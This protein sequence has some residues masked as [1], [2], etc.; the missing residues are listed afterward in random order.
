MKGL[1]WIRAISKGSWGIGML[2]VLFL[3]GCNGSSNQQASQSST[4][5]NGADEPQTV[6][7]T[8]PVALPDDML[9]ASPDSARSALA[10]PT[11]AEAR[12]SQVSTGRH[13]PFSKVTQPLPGAVS[14]RNKIASAP[15]PAVQSSPVASSS[16][17]TLPSVPNAIAPLPNAAPA[18]VSFVPIAPSFPAP[19]SAATSGSGIVAPSSTLPGA[20]PPIPVPSQP[21]GMAAGPLASR[22]AVSGVM[23]VG[24]QISAIVTLPQDGMS[25][26]VRVGDSLAGGQIRVKRIEIGPDREPLVI[27]EQEGQE[28]PRAVGGTSA[29]F[30]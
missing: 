10:K 20:L 15:V 2:S 14:T 28:Y 11:A 19:L 17:G 29:S 16:T 22:V 8:R 26:Y 12:L 7:T 4:P 23:Q 3:M 30:S 24:D 21:S 9:A 13:D 6:L 27:L 25:R 5:Q 1:A 18:Q